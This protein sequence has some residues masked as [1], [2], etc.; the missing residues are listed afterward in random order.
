METQSFF[1]IPFLSSPQDLEFLYAQKCC[2]FQ[3]VDKNQM[4][5]ETFVNDSIQ[6]ALP[7]LTLVKN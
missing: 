2:L 5:T 4:F 3:T 7:E 6:E 1:E